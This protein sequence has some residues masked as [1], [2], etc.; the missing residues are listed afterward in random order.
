MKVAV[1][2]LNA[3]GSVNATAEAANAP[4]ANSATAVPG[5]SWTSQLLIATVALVVAAIP[6]LS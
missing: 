2:I 1:Q 3:D 5:F 4:S 6:V